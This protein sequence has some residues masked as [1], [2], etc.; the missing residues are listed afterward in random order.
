MMARATGL[1]EGCARGGL[2]ADTQP[3]GMTVISG[4]R[5][6]VEHCVDGS[7]D[8]DHEQSQTGSL[9]IDDRR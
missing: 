3:Y 1:E 5:L 4:E 9:R 7:C 8:R 2:L 6:D